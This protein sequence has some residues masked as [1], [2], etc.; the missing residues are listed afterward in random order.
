MFYYY[1]LF[2]LTNEISSF[3]K[4]ITAVSRLLHSMRDT[5][6]TTFSCTS[7]LDSVSR[8]DAISGIWA[9]AIM[10]HHQIPT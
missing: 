9:F 7:G 3:M 1:L 4:R 8:R 10:K 6:R 5:A 2:Q